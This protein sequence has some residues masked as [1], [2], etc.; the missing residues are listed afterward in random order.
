MGGGIGGDGWGD[1]SLFLS[2]FSFDQ[3][4]L[5]LVLLITTL[6]CADAVPQPKVSFAAAARGGAAGRGWEA[7]RW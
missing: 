7:E 5:V 2:F 4:V 1:F 6:A 3:A